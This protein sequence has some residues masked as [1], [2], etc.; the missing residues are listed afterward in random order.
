MYFYFFICALEYRVPDP[1]RKRITTMQLTQV[2]FLPFISL[3]NIT[4]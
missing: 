1:W 3:F 4:I 2:F